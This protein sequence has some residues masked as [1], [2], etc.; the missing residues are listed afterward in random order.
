MS[1]IGAGNRVHKSGLGKV[2]AP[3]EESGLAVLVAAAL[4]RTG[5]RTSET[6]SG[7][8]AGNAVRVHAYVS[9]HAQRPVL[10]GGE[11]RI[12]RQ[13]RR[14]LFAKLQCAAAHP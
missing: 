13:Y 3:A 8:V 2:D 10:Q 1:D 14:S 9:I 6:R 4:H 11:L 7:F 5:A 12:I